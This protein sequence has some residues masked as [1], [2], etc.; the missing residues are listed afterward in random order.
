MVLALIYSCLGWIIFN[1]FFGINNNSIFNAVGR[2]I[3]LFPNY[4][5]IT[6]IETN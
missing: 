2:L 4:Y 1:I 6:S 5:V 3:C